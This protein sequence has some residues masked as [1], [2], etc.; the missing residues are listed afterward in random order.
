MVSQPPPI[1]DLRQKLLSCFRV[2]AQLTLRGDHENSVI[3][4]GDYGLESIV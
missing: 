2:A 3:F 4:Q 1:A